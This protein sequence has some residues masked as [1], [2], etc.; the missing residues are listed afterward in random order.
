MALLKTDC[1]VARRGNPG[2][3]KQ[4]HILRDFFIIF[5]LLGRRLFDKY[6]HRSCCSCCYG[7]WLTFA[8]SCLVV[9]LK[10]I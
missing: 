7:D 6:G 2:R 3:N 8:E 10:V 4:V 9:R 5:I 1:D